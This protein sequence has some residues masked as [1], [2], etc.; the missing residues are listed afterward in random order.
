[1]YVTYNIQFTDAISWGRLFKDTAL[2]ICIVSFIIVIWSCN[3]PKYMGVHIY[4]MHLAGNKACNRTRN[5]NGM[6]GQL[7]QVQGNRGH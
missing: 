2:V 5:A 1:M 6:I 7:K 3:G 4:I